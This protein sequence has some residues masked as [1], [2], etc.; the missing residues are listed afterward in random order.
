M[1]E[2]RWSGGTRLRKGGRIAWTV[3]SA[4]AVESLVFGVSAFP[5]VRL[6]EWV[7]RWSGSPDGLRIVVLSMALVPAY[8]VFALGLTVWS[9]L[10]MR[11]LGWR[12][13]VNA[14]MRIADLD[15][16][17]LRWARYLVSAHVVR[18]FAGSAFRATP[19][20]TFYHRLN[21]ARIGRRVYVNSLTVVDDNLLDFGEGVVIG[22]GVH[23]SGHTV[24]GGVV[25]TAPVRLGSNV[26]IGVGSV[27]GVGVEIGAGTEVGALSVV[28]KHRRLAADAVYGGVPVR[29]LDASTA[30]E[31][32]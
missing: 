4:V 8:L 21:G 13:P 2:D 25:K 1:R 7:F 15:W 32:P 27:I 17:L 29:R 10:A 24:E 16:P 6:W 9:A 26:T 31:L 23:L 18:W 11:V 14:E 22:S 5:A 20:W 28:P 3:V 30:G 19:V 12:T